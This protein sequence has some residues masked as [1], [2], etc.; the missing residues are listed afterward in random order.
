MLVKICQ[1]IF[2][3]MQPALLRSECSLH[4]LIIMIGI[5]TFNF[6]PAIGL[7]TPTVGC[8]H[9]PAALSVTKAA[10]GPLKLNVHL[11]IVIMQAAF[12]PQ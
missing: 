5:R 3:T 7:M 8:L 9:H 10:G 1:K 2:N 11:P 4:Y 6:K 12:R